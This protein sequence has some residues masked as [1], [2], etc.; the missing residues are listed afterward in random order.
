MP[1]RS[2]WCP[3]SR[4]QVRA[5]R[6]RSVGR[7]V[8]GTAG[9]CVL[10]VYPIPPCSSCVLPAAGRG[11]S[12]RQQFQIRRP[13]RRL[14][15]LKNVSILKRLRPNIRPS[16]IHR[17][18][19]RTAASPLNGIRV[20]P[21]VSRYAA[22]GRRTPGT[23]AARSPVHRRPY[24]EG[25][26]VASDR[27]DVCRPERRRRYIVQSAVSRLFE[28]PMAV[29]FSCYNDACSSS[30]SSTNRVTYRCRRLRFGVRR[31]PANWWHACKREKIARVEVRRL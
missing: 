13:R 17:L 23:S 20:Q 7:S 5:V 4:S 25:A 26:A 19:G 8:A 9:G 28:R 30:S 21:S 11:L 27:Q 14:V 6:S 2:I 10:Y 18:L 3:P 15:R 31:E 16:A 22:L 29:V 1:P 24:V 12:R